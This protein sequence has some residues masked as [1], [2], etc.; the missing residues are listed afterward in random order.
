MRRYRKEINI[1][2]TITL[3]DRVRMTDP[4]YGMDVWCSGTVD[5]VLPGEYVPVGVISN[6]GSWG[7][8]VAQ[9]RVNHVDYPMTEPTEFV[10]FEVGVDSG[11]AGIFDEPYYIDH[12]RDNDYDDPSSWYRKVCNIT[13]SSPGIGTIDGKGLVSS[14]GYGDGGYDAYVAR[15]D[16]GKIVA[17]EIDYL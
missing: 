9:I 2:G 13:L 5:N 3:G 10:D 17:I 16:D 15:N 12:H 1:A 6:E 7:E 14:S 11:Q 8:R 4:C